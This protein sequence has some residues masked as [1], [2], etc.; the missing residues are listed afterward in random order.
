MTPGYG[1]RRGFY[2]VFH[3]DDGGRQ[4]P[5]AEPSGRASPGNPAFSNA[6]ALNQRIVRAPCPANAS[7]RAGCL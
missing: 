7:A 4:I 1:V 3:V 2:R 5:A 6:R